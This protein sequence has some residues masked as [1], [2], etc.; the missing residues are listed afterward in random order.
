VSP[1]LSALAVVFLLSLFGAWV[2]FK[3]LNSTAV[4]TRKD[5]Q[6]GGAAAGCLLFFSA[7]YGGYY[8]LEKLKVEEM[9]QQLAAYKSKLQMDE[10][11][12]QL[13]GTV[14]PVP[15]NATVVLATIST[16][17]A[18]DGRFVLSTKGLD[19]AK[20]LPALYVV[21][22]TK[23]WYKQCFSTDDPHNLTIDTQSQK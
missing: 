11:E 6:M 17:L 20:T 2:L 19:F 23:H 3:W 13:M 22:E 21:G 16:T 9:Q 4:I 7:L 10:S 15:K 1:E 18:D 5:Y 12:Q 8:Y 14:S